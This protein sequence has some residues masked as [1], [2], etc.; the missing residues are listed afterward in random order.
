MSAEN[1]GERMREYMKTKEFKSWFLA[2]LREYQ[3]DF[4]VGDRINIGN[5][6]ELLRRWEQERPKDVIDLELTVE[7]FA[8][9]TLF[10][11]AMVE[12]GLRA[13]SYRK[14]GM[15]RKKKEV[16]PSDTTATN[17]GQIDLTNRFDASGDDVVLVSRDE[18]NRM[19]ADVGYIKMHI[20]EAIKANAKTPPVVTA[21]PKRRRWFLFF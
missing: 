3:P 11:N 4:E 6:K 2:T 12:A 10:A 5:I 1:T 19:T 16:E 21:K 18:W 14:P 9:Y 13:V 20:R 7:N 15:S 8:R 17:N